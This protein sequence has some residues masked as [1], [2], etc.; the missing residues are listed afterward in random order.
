MSQ[1]SIP[2]R[3]SNLPN[4][5][6]RVEVPDDGFVGIVIKVGIGLNADGSGQEI[7]KAKADAG[8][9]RNVFASACKV[10]QRA[11]TDRVLAAEDGGTLK[12][13]TTSDTTIT[14]DGDTLANAVSEESLSDDELDRLTDPA[15]PDGQ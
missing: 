1:D 3:D 7:I 12:S 15:D 9:I 5:N 13:A 14:R 8:D 10:I 2:A 4:I 6:D 11:A